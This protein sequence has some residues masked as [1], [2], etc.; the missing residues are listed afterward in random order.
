MKKSIHFPVRIHPTG[1]FLVPDVEN[2]DPTRYKHSH[3]KHS[4]S[5]LVNLIPGGQ[6]CD[7]GTEED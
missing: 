5:F 6:S 4:F 3:I 2:Y 7:G 1:Y